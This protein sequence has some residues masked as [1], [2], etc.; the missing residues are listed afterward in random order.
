MPGHRKIASG[1]LQLRQQSLAAGDLALARRVLH[2]ELFDD[3]VVDQHRITL[4]ARAKAVAG[5]VEGHVDCLGEF[6]VAIGQ[7]IDL[8]LG[9][10]RFLP[11][12]RRR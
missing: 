11:W 7:K 10:G 12:P 8:A 3:T 2:V 5:G 6:A 1:I 4:R 9:A